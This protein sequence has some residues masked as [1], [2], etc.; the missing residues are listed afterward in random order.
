MLM[1]AL[2]MYL[3][4]C[5]LTV[6]NGKVS[7]PGTGQARPAGRHKPASHPS[8]PVSP[9]QAQWS[10]SFVPAWHLIEEETQNQRGAETRLSSHS[11]ALG[12]RNEGMR[13]RALRQTLPWFLY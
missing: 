10:D 3:I 11:G 1:K 13:T 5:L 4:S 8:H 7:A 12:H 6:S 2:L 9:R